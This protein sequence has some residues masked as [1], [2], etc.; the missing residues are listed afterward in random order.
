MKTVIRDS[1]FGKVPVDSLDHLAHSTPVVEK[2]CE[3]RRKRK[4]S[5]PPSVNK[6]VIEI[7]PLEL[8]NHTTTIQNPRTGQTK[9]LVNSV[10]PLQGRNH[11]ET[12]YN[13]AS[14]IKQKFGKKEREEKNETPP[15]FL[16]TLAYR[17]IFP[18][19]Y[20][21]FLDSSFYYLIIW[22][23]YS[24]NATVAALFGLFMCMVV[25]WITTCYILSEN[26]NGT[27]LAFYNLF[28]CILIFPIVLFFH[29]LYAIGCNSKLFTTRVTKAEK[30]LYKWSPVCWLIEFFAVFF[31]AQK[32]PGGMLIP[33]CLVGFLSQ[34]LPILLNVCGP[35][36]KSF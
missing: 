21:F 3:A 10:S 20:C 17:F 25:G 32:I 24:F 15:N 9:Y 34:L 8:E 26:L 12:P 2:D 7:A 5:A 4:H 13:S 6:T 16:A 23:H 29:T 22:G 19:A 11:F 14:Y 28:S 35:G 18:L 31:D 27:Q 33:I 30:F 36:E 1:Q